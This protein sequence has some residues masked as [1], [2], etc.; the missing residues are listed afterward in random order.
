MCDETTVEYWGVPKYQSSNLAKVA[1]AM[2]N[3]RKLESQCE[4]A[5][6]KRRGGLPRAEAKT[7]AVP[8]GNAEAGPAV[9]K[10]YK[11]LTP[12]QAKRVA[13]ASEALTSDSLALGELIDE[14][15]KEAYAR[16]LPPFLLPLAKVQQA[17]LEEASA[18][19]DIISSDAWVG[20]FATSFED[21]APAR[22]AAAGVRNKL[23]EIVDE[24]RPADG[25]GVPLDA[26][27]KAK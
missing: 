1:S 18:T 27:G 5:L 25:H 21:V 4:V 10:G 22:Q 16:F 7:V 8:V 20:M 15:E 24:H 23:Q 13:K 9:P 3:K 14:V 11:P 17:A 12:T 26:K 6:P 2:S 19:L